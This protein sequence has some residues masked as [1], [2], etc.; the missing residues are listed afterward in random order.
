MTQ[1]ID[2]LRIVLLNAFSWTSTIAVLQLTADILQVAA[3]FGSVT[4]SIFSVRWISKQSKNFD[5]LNKASK[6]NEPK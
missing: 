3:L 4:V 6:E 2:S 5:R 1:L